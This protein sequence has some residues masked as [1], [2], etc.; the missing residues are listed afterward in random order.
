MITSYFLNIAIDMG[1]FPTANSE[2]IRTL[3]KAPKLQELVRM[4]DSSSDV[5]KVV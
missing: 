3:L 5:E 2:E 1:S 4:I